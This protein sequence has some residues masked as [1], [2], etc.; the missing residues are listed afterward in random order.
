VAEVWDADAPAVAPGPGA[1][2]QVVPGD[3]LLRP[4]ES[5]ALDVHALDALGATAVS[6]V[7]DVA[8]AGPPNLDLAFESRAL[9]DGVAPGWVLRVPETARTGSGVV[10][11]TAG[12]LTG[13]VRVRVAPA[14]D[15]AEDFEGFELTE[16]EAGVPFAHPSGFWVG[17]RLKWDVRELDGGKVLAKTLHTPLFQRSLTFFGH[18]DAANYTMQ[19][20]IRTDGSRRTMS[21]AG[22]LHQGYLI[23]LKGNHQELEVSSNTERLQQAVP[24]EWKPDTWY[25]L[26]TRVEADPAA[27]GAGTVHA[28]VW[29]RGEPEPEGWM[30]SVPVLH[31]HPGG[32][33][34]L[35][36]FTPQSRFRV[37]VDNLRVTSNA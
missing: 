10:K 22:V 32:S 23:A 34:G 27:P 4:G 15:Y 26:V 11:A 6:A 9:D 21:T 29:P 20:D 5:V 31:L 2:L 13:G 36:G 37:Y 12:E 18:A 16:N 17:G 28:K 8:W 24:F 7:L 35:F 30:L 3:L 25:T 14:L 1:R 33:P 19:A